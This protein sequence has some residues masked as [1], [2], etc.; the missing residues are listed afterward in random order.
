MFDFANTAI[1]F[2]SWLIAYED[3]ISYEEEVSNSE[4]VSIKF[5]VINQ[6]KEA[7]HHL[8]VVNFDGD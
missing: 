8:D 2:L 4:I 7:M 3:K 6:I 5:F 1:L